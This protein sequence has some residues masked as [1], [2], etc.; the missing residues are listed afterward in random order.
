MNE[1]DFT[2]GDGEAADEQDEPLRVAPAERKLV[3][4]P[5]DYSV[6]TLAQRVAS[7]KL[8]LD[9]DYQRKHVWDTA[10]ASRLIESLIM[11]V[12][13]PVCYFAEIDNARHE[14]IDGLQRITAIVN[15]L[16]D[17]YSLRGISVLEELAGKHFSQ[18]NCWS[19]RPRRQ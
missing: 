4:Q 14:V 17:E 11:N 10:K 7:G 19:A 6:E 9:I 18:L 5:Y 2:D 3:T 15:F 8:V 13:V 16:R 12:P 1:L